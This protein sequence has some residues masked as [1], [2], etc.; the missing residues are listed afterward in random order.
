MQTIRLRLKEGV[1]SGV[2]KIP[3]EVDSLIPDN[4]F[5]KNEAEI[6]AVKVWWGNRQENTGDLFDVS[7]EGTA[8][9]A[10]EVK[11]AFEGDLTRVKHI[12]DSMKA[13]EIEAH[14]NV[15]MHCG[16][17]M[18]G[19]RVIVK[20]NADCWA[21]REMRGGELVIEGDAAD[22]LCAM[23]RGEM[24]GMTGG[25]VT[26]EGDAGECVGQYMAGGEILIK[27]NADVLAGYAMRGGR[28]VIE[29]DAAIPGADMIKGE[30]IVK[31]DVEM[32]PSFK[33]IGVEM[34]EAEKYDKYIGDYAMGEK[35][36]KGT[37][38]VKKK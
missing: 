5:G 28:I 7:V 27:G 18:E 31:G 4:L 38:Y 10:G 32:L 16:A 2:A 29:G 8:G 3:I 26:V 1:M 21:G 19:G 22:N 33:Y 15:D 23:Y 37:L 36:A 11:I 25:K 20:G 12:G 9:S 6:K 30:I 34:I 24:T 35:K 13:G 17:V 14:G